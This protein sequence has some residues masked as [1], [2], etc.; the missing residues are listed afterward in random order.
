MLCNIFYAFASLQMAC[1][2]GE[3][4]VEKRVVWNAFAKAI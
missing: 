4:A 3:K 1:R 2:Q